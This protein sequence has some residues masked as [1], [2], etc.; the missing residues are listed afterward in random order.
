MG[1]L[2]TVLAF[3]AAPLYRDAIARR[4]PAV[5]PV[6]VARLT[7]TAD[8]KWVDPEMA[9]K[10]GMY[11]WAGQQ[12][13]LV[14]GLAEIKYLSGAKVILEGPTTFELESK[15]SGSLRVGRLTAQV[16]RKPS[17]SGSARPL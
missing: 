6:C 7:R 3:W 13:E 16:R 10:P 4:E 2:L 11:L 15:G 14:E 8:C 9:P 12:L 1:S 17:G 5:L